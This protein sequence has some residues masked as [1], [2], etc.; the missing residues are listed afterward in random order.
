MQP[1]V[2][3]IIYMQIKIKMVRRNGSLELGSE[4][5]VYRTEGGKKAQRAA[6]R[7]DSA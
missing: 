7:E 6:T 2:K 1:S 4:V 3:A 5:L